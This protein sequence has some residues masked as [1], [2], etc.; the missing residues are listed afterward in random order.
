MRWLVGWVGGRIEHMSFVSY[1]QDDAG[2]GRLLDGD[3]LLS[4][5]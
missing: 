3:P 2:Q 4:Q 5:E 1:W